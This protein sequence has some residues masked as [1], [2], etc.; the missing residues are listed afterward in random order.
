MTSQPSPQPASQPQAAPRGQP[1]FFLK[2]LKIGQK[3]AIGFGL[4]VLLTFISAGVS[5]LGS[6][7]ATDKIKRTDDLRVPT[8]LTASRAQANLL[9][10]LADV[11]GYLALGDQKYRDSYQQS[12]QYLETN[13]AEL[14][15][16]SPNLD[17]D[18]QVRLVKLGITYNQ[19][20]DL[21]PHLFELRDDQLDREPAYRL[22]ATKGTTSAGA[23]LIAISQ[24]IELQGQR[25]ASAD[26]LELLRDMAKFQGNFA[27][28]LSSLRGYVTTR[29]RIFR[30]EYEVNLVDNQ[31]TW[32]RLYSKRDKLTTSQQGLLTKIVHNRAEFLR[33]PEQMFADLESDRW[34]EDLYLFSTQ[35]VPLA[36][37]MQELLKGLVDDQQTLLASEL[38]AGS[39]DLAN[40]NQLILGGGVL[41]LLIGL[42]LAYTAQATI[43]G[44]IRRL[45]SVAERIRGGDLEAQASVESK[46]E[47]G[48][49]AGTFNAMT[50]QL[51]RTL[52]Q[53]R[54]EKKRADDLLHVV[55]PIGVDLASEKDFNRLLEK[56]LLEAKTFCHADAGTLYLLNTQAEQLE[57]VIVRNDTQALALGGTTNQPVTFAPLP[58]KD[59]SSGQPNLGYVATRVAINGDSINI[60]DAS[61]AAD[62]D[63]ARPDS[64][65]AIVGGYMVKSMLTIPLKNSQGDVLGVLQLINAQDPDSGQIIAFDQNL[66][67]MMES[68]SSL[69]VAAL[70]AYIREQKLRQEIQ[71]LRIE[72]DEAK[73]QQQVSEIVDTDFFQDLRAKARNLR[74]RGRGAEAGEEEEA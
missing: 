40:A 11:R 17:A 69:A 28:M 30:G 25:E 23:V 9:R 72:I 19:W 61:L 29:N 73:R 67:Q 66:Q 74:R 57:F 50:S 36:D 43:A 31:N 39:Q 71:Q 45:T 59:P 26:N 6:G 52:M 33:L 8:A 12:T 56:M 37:E 41:A 13:L 47:V 14:D 3:L 32:D 21:P 24:L 35:S 18:N 46:D 70:E 1:L 55:I 38:K 65:H 34:R 48:I 20:K 5:Y 2:D 54:K 27:A 49:L 53:V 68:F 60:Q 7:Q 64:R 22:L 51:R 4:L 42:G 62:F 16:L 10:M 15:R 58:L 44:P 63:F